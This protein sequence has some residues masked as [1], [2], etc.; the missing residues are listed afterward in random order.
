MP[1]YVH[2]TISKDA[3]VHP[4]SAGYQHPSQKYGTKVI[5]QEVD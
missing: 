1:E 4:S 2:P 5:L 3:Y